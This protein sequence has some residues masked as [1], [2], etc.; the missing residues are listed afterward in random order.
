VFDLFFTTKAVGEGTDRLSMVH[1]IGRRCRER[2]ASTAGPVWA[3]R[4]DP[5]AGHFLRTG[6]CRATSRSGRASTRREARD[7]RGR[8]A[9]TQLIK[10]Q[11]EEM[12]YAVRMHTGPK[13]SRI[14]GA[15]RGVR[16]VDHRQHHA[17][18]DGVELAIAAGAAS[19]SPIPMISGIGATVDAATLSEKGIAKV[20]SKPHSF[21]QLEAALRSIL[22][23]P[24]S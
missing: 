20:L 14:P 16:S 17:A 18:P 11:L 19:G 7:A 15:S 6:P 24:A 23:T 1:G 8:R 3:E 10:R 13:R 9:A 4:R 12:G 21:A 2:S 5:A 22:G